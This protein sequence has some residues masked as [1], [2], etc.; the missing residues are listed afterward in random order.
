[1]AARVLAVVA[2]LISLGVLGAIVAITID[3]GGWPAWWFIALLVLAASGLGY[4]ATNG[5]HRVAVV[6]ST[7]ILMILLGV[8]A[9]LT[10]G[11]PLL[12]AGVL[13]LVSAGATRVSAC[14]AA[15]P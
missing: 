6:T 12:V 5:P 14:D 10:V 11:L 1:M 3:Q 4:G 15:V 7:S 8:L 9:L 13:G 2:A